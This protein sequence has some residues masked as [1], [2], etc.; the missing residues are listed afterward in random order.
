MNGKESSTAGEKE[1]VF[2][3]QHIELCGLL[4]LENARRIQCEDPGSRCGEVLG[5]IVL[6][7]NGPESVREAAGPARL[8]TQ[9]H[10]FGFRPRAK[11][12]AA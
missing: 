4:L 6:V 8:C 12:T 7:Q 1:R 11:A 5:N 3:R 9:T 2:C 10:V